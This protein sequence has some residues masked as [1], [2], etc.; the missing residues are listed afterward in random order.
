MNRANAIALA[1]LLLCVAPLARAQDN[2]LREQVPY[3][4]IYDALPER[5]PALKFPEHYTDLDKA[6]AQGFAGRYKLALMTL[7]KVKDGNPVEMAL[8]KAHSLAA[9]G[10]RTEAIAALSDKAVADDGRVQIARANVLADLGQLREAIALLKTHL[11]KNPKSI[12]GHYY[13]GALNERLGNLT[14][15]RDAYKWLFD[16]CFDKWQTT[17]GKDPMF[18]KAEEV[19]DMARGFDRWA[20][21]ELLYQKDANMPGAVLSVFTRVADTI[22]LEYW[23][24][25]LAAAEYLLLHD[26]QKEAEGELKRAL[27]GNPQDAR[28]HE[29][30]AHMALSQWN[31]DAVDR[32]IE[33]IRSVDPTSVASDVLEARNFLQQRR[34]QDAEGPIGRVLKQQPEHIEAMGLLAATYALELKD[35]KMNQ[36]IAAVEKLD[37]NNA[38]AYLELAEQLGAMRQYPRAE[39]MYKIAIQRAPWWTDARNGLGLLYTQ[40]GDEDK[41]RVVLDAARTLDPF[42]HRTYNYILLLN[43]LD[44]FT[45]KETKHFVLMYKPDE[46][47]LIADYFVD[48]LES[49]Y[50]AV[51][52]DFKFEPAVT[53]YIEVFPQHDQF[54]VRTTG[55]PW[56][57]TVGASTGRVIALVTPRKGEAT[58]G[59]YN[60]AQVL[61]HE[62]THT[63][64]LGATDNRIAHWMTEGLA[65]QEEHSPMRW[66]WVPMLYNAVK[67]HEL[68][69]MDGLTWGFVRPKRPIDRQLAYAQSFWICE[70]IEQ[71]FGRDSLLKMMD[72]FKAGKT[73]E[74]VFQNVLGKNLK[75][76]TKDFFAWTDQQVA[77]WGYDAA[78]TSKYETLT[79]KGADLIA[80]KQWDKAIEV[81]QEVEKVRPVDALPHQRLAGLYLRAGKTDKAIDELD[82]LNKVALKDNTYAKAIARIYLKD[83]KLDQA[84]KYAMNAIYIEPYDMAAHELMASIAE[85][86]GDKAALEREKKMM[87]LLQEWLDQ[88]RESIQIPGDVPPAQNRD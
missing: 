17:G 31:F 11:D 67:H 88:N 34:P 29:L 73:Q 84:K 19:T 68:F 21:L 63:V 71:K 14:A 25:H 7:N 10:K 81:W 16:N 80:A 87:P 1:L 56:I 59:T 28:S 32:E 26:N 47:P 15:A 49:I 60:W 58:M 54:S 20:T 30:I 52:S 51:C 86:A 72:E 36:E 6:R 2:L 18:E 38:T 61:R 3:R 70:Y 27:A 39:A 13:M 50:A 83:D 33:T 75:E 64:T 40:S 66:E 45:K 12:S 55:S 4:W 41:A 77:G 85:K 57:G 65:V 44:K 8:I 23:P 43:D 9:M 48:Y 62:F 46:D 5:L 53:T 76:F 74:Q 42:N 37:P 78:G 69:T 82:A 24:A 22:D 35:D 79:K